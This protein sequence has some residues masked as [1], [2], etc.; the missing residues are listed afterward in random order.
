MENA[1]NT[2]TFL[3]L[4]DR[5]QSYWFGR[6]LERVNYDSFTFSSDATAHHCSWLSWKSCM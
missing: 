4:F 5:S 3:K 6:T 1:N 2:R